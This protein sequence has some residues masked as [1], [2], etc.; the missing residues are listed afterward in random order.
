MQYGTVSR[1]GR[2]Q[3]KDEDASQDWVAAGFAELARGSGVDNVRVEVLATRLG[4]T[5]GG[6]YRRFKD[7]RALLDAILE[8][9]RDGRIAA[10]ERHSEEG[11]RTPAERLRHLAKI[12][13]ERANEQGMAIELAIRQWARS[14][15]AA[16]AAVASVDATR[17]KVA[18]SLFRSGGL[19]APDAD[20]RAVTFYA[21]L[22]GQSLMFLDESPRRRANLIAACTKVLTEVE[23]R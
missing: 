21:F 8:A 9:W 3:A 17:L 4:V 10:I 22:F 14:D 15:Q 20:A 12:Y 1:V 11:G 5:K 18:S 6:F 7:R 23:Q 13:T 19:P 2:A 16:A